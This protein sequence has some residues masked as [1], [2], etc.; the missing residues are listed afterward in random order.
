MHQR[1][2]Q[3]LKGQFSELGRKLA[4]KGRAFN[5]LGVLGYSYIICSK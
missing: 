2:L 4:E 5:H 3:T 1:R